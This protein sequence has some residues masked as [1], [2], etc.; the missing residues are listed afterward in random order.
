MP[1]HNPVP[2]T[3][4][5]WME[6]AK[7]K[8]AL[9]YHPLPPGAFWEDL[10]FLDHQAAE[11]AIKA[12][13]IVHGWTFPFIHDLGDLL[14]ELERQGLSIPMGILEADQLSQ[15]AVRA[16]YPG[17]SAPATQEQFQEALK[18][19]EEVVVWAQTFLP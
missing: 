13:F 11:L 14:E 9:A 4:R 1:T 16:R 6:R 8:L 12:V 10:C 19:A 2:G 3:A 15:Y 17:F 18:I 7:G 5:E